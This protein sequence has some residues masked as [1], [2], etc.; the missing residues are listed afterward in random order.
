MGNQCTD[1][2]INGYN[3]QTTP[4]STKLGDDVCRIDDTRVTKANGLAGAITYNDGRIIRVLPNSVQPDPENPGKSLLYFFS[5]SNGGITPPGRQQ[6]VDLAEIQLAYINDLNG[7]DPVAK[8]NAGAFA[9]IGGNFRLYTGESLYKGLVTYDD[10][11]PVQIIAGDDASQADAAH[12]GQFLVTVRTKDNTGTVVLSLSQYQIELLQGMQTTELNNLA[13]VQ[14]DAILNLQGTEVGLCHNNGGSFS[15]E[16]I[17]T[18]LGTKS[19][20]FSPGQQ[21]GLESLFANKADHVFFC[22]DSSN[23]GEIGVNTGT[24]SKSALDNAFNPLKGQCSS[25]L[26]SDSQDQCKVLDGVAHSLGL[27]KDDPGFWDKYGT[28]IEGLVGGLIVFFVAG[29]WIHKK[30]FEGKGPTGPIDPNRPGGGPGGGKDIPEL[31]NRDI[32]KLE[33]DNPG[34]VF[35]GSDGLIGVEGRG[36]IGRVPKN[37]WN[38]RLAGVKAQGA[39]VN[40]G[41]TEGDPTTVFDTVDTGNAT[42]IRAS[43]DFDEQE[44]TGERNYTPVAKIDGVLRDI[45][46]DPSLQEGKEYVSVLVNDPITRESRYKYHLVGDMGSP[47][48]SEN[49]I[50]INDGD[51]TAVE[52]YSSIGNNDFDEGT[53]VENVPNG[54]VVPTSPAYKEFLSEFGLTEESS[55]TD[56]IKAMSHHKQVLLKDPRMGRIYRDLTAKDGIYG[57]SRVR[58]YSPE[59]QQGLIRKLV[60]DRLTTAEPDR[61]KWRSWQEIDGEFY[62]DV[63][64]PRQVS[65]WENSQ[66][67]D[68]IVGRKTAERNMEEKEDLLDEVEKK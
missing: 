51:Y 32:Q 53:F 65:M 37:Y 33:A 4:L 16:D 10:G 50:E 61:N 58:L 45:G 68:T 17:P 5:L 28:A 40:A 57:D 43:S 54:P 24:Q 44:I 11:R 9:T 2:V 60:E 62:A 64:N 47:E 25:L 55:M 8:A 12:P 23:R 30:L 56:V 18:A 27:R 20:L 41:L 34:K 46:F 6:P 52:D 14:R 15:V 38:E 35:Y 7:Q 42:M 63:V 29:P 39:T 36:V 19:V 21:R 26:G 1:Y 13:P 3:G 31:S 48:V 59:E 22:I 49:E 67:V 66:S